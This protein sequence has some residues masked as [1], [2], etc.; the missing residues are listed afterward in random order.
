MTDD[1]PVAWTGAPHGRWRDRSE[2]ALVPS[3]VDATTFDAYGPE[4]ARPIPERRMTDEQ[5][6]GAERAELARLRE[7]YGDS[8]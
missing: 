2:D 6:E 8:E 4:H 7:K 5:I 1:N 3:P